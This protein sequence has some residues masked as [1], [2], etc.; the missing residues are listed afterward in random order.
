MKSVM[1]KAQQKQSWQAGDIFAVQQRDGVCSLGCV[2]DLMMKNVVSCAFYDIRAKCEDK[3]EAGHLDAARLIALLSVTR[4]QL[5][6]GAWKIVG[7]LDEPLDKELWP[8]EEYREARWIGA[9]IYDAAIAEDLLNAYNGLA[10]WDDWHDPEY[11]DKLL[12]A[13]DRKPKHVIYKKR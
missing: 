2:I 6:F 8:N 7:H 3:I 13:P 12:V 11:L 4:E 5:D 9:K 1:P 10:A